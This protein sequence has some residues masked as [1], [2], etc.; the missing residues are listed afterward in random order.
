M[1]LN[2]Q[3]RIYKILVD[4]PAPS[5]RSYARRLDTRTYGNDDLEYV[6]YTGSYINRREVTLYLRVSPGKYL[7]IPSLYEV[8]SSSGKRLV[9]SV[10]LLSNSQI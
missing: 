5:P 4:N 9:R 10:D 8:R 1:S 3:A 6:G 7:V 2:S